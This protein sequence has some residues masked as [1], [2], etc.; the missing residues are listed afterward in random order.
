MKI[1]KPKSANL[2]LSKNKISNLRAERYLLG[3]LTAA[4]QL[5][6]ELEI[7]E[8][9]ELSAY[10]SELKGISSR[11]NWEQIRNQ[12]PVENVVNQPNSE[13]F[14]MIKWLDRFLPKT[15]GPVLR[16]GGALAMVLLLTPFLW[17]FNSETFGLRSKGKASPEIKL[18]IG[19]KQ[20]EAGQRQSAFS[21]DIMTFSYRSSKPIYTQIW[22]V[23]DLGT[24]SLFDGRTDS[25]LFW[26]ATSSWKHAPQRIR[27]EGDWKSQKV[28]IITSQKPIH[29]E[30]AQRILKGDQKENGHTE[31]FTY[32]LY[33]P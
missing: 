5:S 33:Q 19:G 24:L 18:E 14:S 22:Y 8:N 16:W 30:D 23:E 6:F 31:I 28:I 26:P 21:G 17:Q 3:E 2:E 10:I 11:L 12:L 7:R 15:S 27:L 32:E 13:S 4:D 29:L 25:S 1:D 9:P 20:L